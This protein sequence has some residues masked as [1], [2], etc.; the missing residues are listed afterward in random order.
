MLFRTLLSL[1]L[2]TSPYLLAEE[3]NGPT[4]LTMKIFDTLK[5]NGPAKLELVKAARLE[6]NGPLEFSRLDVKENAEIHGPFKGFKGMF[7]ILS[8]KG[9]VSV[10]HL[11][12]N[13]FIIEGPLTATSLE[14]RK[15][16]S[17]KGPVEITEGTLDR[18]VVEG[19]KIVLDKVKVNEIHIKDTESKAVLLLKGNSKVEGNVTFES[20]DGEVKLESGS[21]ING[22]V[23]GG[24]TSS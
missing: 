2:F 13:E 9:P 15:R 8:V 21:R 23:H 18:L 4:S 5:V 1:I 7:D 11:I 24:K 12:A 17:V 6:V 3:F 16:L 10:D 20:G 22:S 19:K 14:V